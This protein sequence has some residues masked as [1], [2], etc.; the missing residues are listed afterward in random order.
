MKSRKPEVRIAA[1]VEIRNL[2]PSECEH[3]QLG[4][5]SLIKI[6]F[7]ELYFHERMDVCVISVCGL[8]R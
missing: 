1:L 3:R 5:V 8:I 2:V 7:M 6:D 4:S